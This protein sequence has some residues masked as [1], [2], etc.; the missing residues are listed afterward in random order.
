M[1]THNSKSDL[2]LDS[3]HVQQRALSSVCPK[4]ALLGPMGLSRYWSKLNFDMGRDLLR[5]HIIFYGDYEN[6]DVDLV[7]HAQKIFRKIY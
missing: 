4:D 1:V 6:I 7:L 5:N 3:T 2:P